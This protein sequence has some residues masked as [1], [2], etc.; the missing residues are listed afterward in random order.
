MSRTLAQ[1]GEFG[2]ID[3]I[4]EIIEKEGAPLP[5]NTLRI[6]DDCAA[7][8]PRPGYD[9]LVTCDRLV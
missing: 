6:G 1:V 7:F 3:Q 9:L 8:Q 2:L 5:K 4:H